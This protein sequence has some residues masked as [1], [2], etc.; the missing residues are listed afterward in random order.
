MRARRV[1]G[2]SAFSL[3]RIRFGRLAAG[4]WLVVLVYMESS[5]SLTM[6]YLNLRSCVGDA[7]VWRGLLLLSR[8]DGVP[9]TGTGRGCSS[10]STGEASCGH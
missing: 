8:D 7:V 6:F 2:S 3:L 5:A 9:A 10:V 1:G 4:I